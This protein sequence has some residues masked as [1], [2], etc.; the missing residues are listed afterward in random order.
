MTPREIDI[1]RARLADIT[2]TATALAHS[3]EDLYRLGYEKGSA[4]NEVKVAGG[5]APADLGTHGDPRARHLWHKLERQ[6]RACEVAL[7][8]VLHGA[9]NLLAE[10]ELDDRLRFGSAI[11]PAEFDRLLAR[12]AHRRSS[13]DYTPHRIEEQ[14]DHPG[15]KRKGKRR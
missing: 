11:T 12:Q 9:G 6:A 5:R 1:V 10:G 3:A 4:T 8:A 2:A 13:G 15:R 14:S 7:R